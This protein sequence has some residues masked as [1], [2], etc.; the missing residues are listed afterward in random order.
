MSP[1]TLV[2]RAESAGLDS[3]AVTDHNTMSAVA[4]AQRA[5]SEEFLVIP[6]E[7][8][9]TPDGQ[10]IG[11]FH[12]DSIDPWQP[13]RKTI[14]QIHEQGGLAITPHPFDTM[15]SGLNSLSEYTDIIDAVETINSRCIRPDYNHRAQ[16]F[17]RQYGL[18]ETGGSDAHFA[19]EIGKA[20]TEVDIKPDESLGDSLYDLVKQSLR[21]GRVAAVG[22]RGSIVSHAGTKCVKLYNRLRQ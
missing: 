8:I 13:P 4:P 15:R 19:H 16:E 20:Y 9:D 22:N 10:I 3:V 17:A 21:D 2:H 6:G 1:K 14:R 18:P 11:L 12:S 5:A 7:E